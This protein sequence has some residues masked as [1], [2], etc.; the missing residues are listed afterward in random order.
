MYGLSV[1]ALH[2]LFCFGH[3]EGDKLVSTHALPLG[4]PLSD[5]SQLAA[6]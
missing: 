3:V 4:L 2:C 5:P 1:G 6:L